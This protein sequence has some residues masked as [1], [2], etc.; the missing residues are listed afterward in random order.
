MIGMDSK[1]RAFTSLELILCIGAGWMI[2][3]FVD[4]IAKRDWFRIAVGLGY[5]IVTYRRTSPRL[6]FLS[7]YRHV[8]IDSVRSSDG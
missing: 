3:P 2:W 8:A 1:Q 6:W 7:P 5:L 4:A